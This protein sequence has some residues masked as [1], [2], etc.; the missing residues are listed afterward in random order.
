M[1]RRGCHGLVNDWF[2]VGSVAVVKIPVPNAAGKSSASP[3]GRPLLLKLFS[4]PNCNI[5]RSNYDV[6]VTVRIRQYQYLAKIG[7]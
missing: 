4:P 1:G 7:P 2:S 5:L 6:L 3:T